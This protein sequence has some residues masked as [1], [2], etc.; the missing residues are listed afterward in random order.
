MWANV[1]QKQIITKYIS[2]FQTPGKPFI[3]QVT[4]YTRVLVYAEMKLLDRKLR[5][6]L[7]LMTELLV[8]RI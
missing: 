5:G 7:Q 3:F 1:F 6:I 8:E 2:L 4:Y